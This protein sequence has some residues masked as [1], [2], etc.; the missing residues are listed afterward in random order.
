MVLWELKILISTYPQCF[1]FIGLS[2]LTATLIFRS[3][4][5]EFLA[6]LHLYHSGAYKTQKIW[7]HWKYL[8]WPS[9][10]LATICIVAPKWPIVGAKIMNIGIQNTLEYHIFRRFVFQWSK[11]NMA[12]ILF[13]FPMLLTI[14]KPNF[15]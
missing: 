2:I 15:G 1:M 14:G 9:W 8:Q 10:A 3:W 6:T 5:G 7:A 4:S 12:T 13:G 11:N